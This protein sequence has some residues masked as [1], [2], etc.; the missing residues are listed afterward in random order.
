MAEPNF[1]N[2]TLWIHDN[3]P[4]LRGINSECI[5]LV[6]LD[7]PFNSK[8][9]YNAPLGSDA[10]G[11]Q[12]EDTWTMDGVKEE[13]LDLQEAADPALYHT[14]VGAGLAAGDPMQ[15]YLAFMAPRLTEI[16]RVLK[17]NGTMYLHCDTH[18]AHYLKQL[19][20]CIF[21]QSRF[22]NEIAWKRT[23]T[24]SLGTRRYARDGDRI[25]Y[26]TKSSSDF[27]WN[28]QYRP[29]DP[30]YVRKNYRHDDGD[31]LG[32]Y[33]TEQLTGGKTGGPAAYLPFKDTLPSE[34]RAWAPPRRERFPSA[35][36][37]KLPDDYEQLDALSK[38]EAL[39][40]A[41]LLRWSRNR[42]PRYKSYLASK[43]GNPASDIITHIP[44]VAGKEATGW[45]TQKPLALYEHF[46]AASS[47]PG[48]LVLD[49][50]CGCATTMVAAERLGRQWAG[51]DIDEVAI[52]ITQKRLQDESDAAVHNV[53]LDG[54]REGLPALHLPPRPPVRTDPDRPTRSRNI[55]AIR[56]AQLGTGERRPCPGCA[57]RKYLDDFDLDH[58]TPRSQGGLDADENLQLLCSPCNRIKGGRLTMT[59][60]RQRLQQRL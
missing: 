9:L 17:P 54:L 4:V 39:D 49:P 23:S 2:R 52:G 35:A 15:A 3:L 28:Q 30:E 47:N 59:E 18:A 32:P 56:W 29:H 46:I 25:L 45:P 43:Q 7:P 22:R 5:D 36:A 48:D 14:V 6:C 41:G 11:A 26:Y 20:D 38:C 37:A 1:L 13:W 42:V 12:F 51:V 16:W 24:K 19:C 33:A 8:R 60:L 50:F 44:P 27:V 10:A 31:G 58:I 21:G 57:R 55:R 40:D 53:D 34:G